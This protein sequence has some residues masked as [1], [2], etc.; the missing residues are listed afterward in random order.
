MNAQQRQAR[1]SHE[2]L[3]SR[4]R[5]FQ[6]TI[7]V[8]QRQIAALMRTVEEAAKQDEARA[9]FIL[10]LEHDAETFGQ[11]AQERGKLIDQLCASLKHAHEENE[12][13]PKL[14]RRLQARNEELAL[15]Q[16]KIHALEA[17]VRGA[18]AAT[19]SVYRMSAAPIAE[20][21]PGE[22]GELARLREFRAVVLR[23]N[24]TQQGTSADRK[25]TEELQRAIVLEQRLAGVGA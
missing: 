16:T 22:R 7:E 4:L 21:E 25:A 9:A 13:A 14:R 2:E 15:A 8:Q 10:E 6:N 11:L 23:Y 12:Y 18:R 24:A 20:L 19:P 17:E 1:L 3:E 5:Q